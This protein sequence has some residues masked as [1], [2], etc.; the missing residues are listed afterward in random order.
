MCLW[1]SRRNAKEIYSH[2]LSE[3]GVL[4]YQARSLLLQLRWMEIAKAFCPPA[5]ASGKSAICGF[6][7]PR[8]A[9][10]S[11]L[12]SSRMLSPPITLHSAP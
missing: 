1:P 10:A 6:A 5:A 9:L 8:R 7:H 2:Y 12:H 4:R 11:E 3:R